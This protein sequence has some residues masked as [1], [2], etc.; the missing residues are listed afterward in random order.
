MRAPIRFRWGKLSAVGL[1]ALG[2]GVAL[3]TGRLAPGRVVAA[4]AAPTFT[5]VYPLQPTEGV[6]AYARISPDGRQLAYASEMPSAQNPRIPQRTVTV[7][8]LAAQKVLYREPGIDAYWSLDGSRM[9]YSGMAMPSGVSIRHSDTGEIV[10]GV[11]PGNLGDYYSWAVRDGKNL[12]L[13]ILSNYYYLD[14]DHGVLPAV[15]VASCPGIG[16]GDRPLISKDGRRITTFVRGNIVVRD[17][18][19]CEGIFDTGI[20]GAKADF[21]WDGRYIAFHAPKP[22]LKGYEIEV[23]D[24]TDRTVRTVTNLP[25]SSLFPSWTKDGRLCFRYDA[26]DYRG[27]VIA[28]HVL[29]APA[30]LLPA[31]GTPVPAAPRWADLFPETPRPAEKVALVMIWATWS[32][33]S[34]QA[35]VDLQAAGTYFR[36]QGADATVLTALE[37]G[38][39][40]ADVDQMR[41]ANGITLPEI[42]LS[43][44]HFTQTEALNQIPTTLLFRDGV[45]VDRRLGAQSFEEL[46]AWVGQALAQH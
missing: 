43:P 41:R 20:Q 40:R 9:I 45:A 10:R 30:R 36:G 24:T 44:R 28:D 27:F 32:A 42:P 3:G 39:L 15:H 11:V 14:G 38:S 22:D 6:F 25:G 16:V 26:A 4:P 29:D 33:H 37:I 23:V 34:P 5:R 12:I 19:D 7:V 2:L 8:D 35:L 18:T 31:K 13:T 17:L 21:S 1:A 46:R